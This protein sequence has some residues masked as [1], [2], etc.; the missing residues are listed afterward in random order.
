[1]MD[2]IIC[3][4]RYP[5]D[6]TNNLK[7]HQHFVGELLDCDKLVL[8]S[9]SSVLGKEFRVFLKDGTVNPDY[10]LINGDNQRDCN[11][12]VPSFIDCTKAYKLNLTEEVDINKLSNRKIPEKIRVSIAEKIAEIKRKGK[13]TEYS[14]CIKEFISNN[15]KSNRI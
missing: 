9:I 6:P 14:I 1:M 3:K 2:I 5:N 12:N 15:P 8:Y 11:L 13:H 7:P 10:F 4:I